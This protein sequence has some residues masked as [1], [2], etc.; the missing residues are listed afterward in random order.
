M[1][2][3]INIYIINVSSDFWSVVAVTLSFHPMPPPK[4]NNIR[5]I[6]IM[7]DFILVQSIRIVFL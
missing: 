7:E 6:N 4:I 5:E 1:S 3:T 2:P